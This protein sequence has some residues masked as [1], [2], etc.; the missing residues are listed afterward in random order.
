MANRK[1]NK[2][3]H[4]QLFNRYIW[5]IDLIYSRKRITFE[6]ICERW[7]R[8]TLNNSGDELPLRTFHNHRK[9]IEQMFDINIECDKRAGYLYYIENS[10]D[11]ER[12]GVRQWLVNTFAVNNLINESH[13][14]KSRILFEEIPSGQ[15][16]LTQIIEAMR[17]GITLE[18][19]YHSFWR[20]H[21]STFIIEPYCVKVF[22]QRWYVVA[23]SVYDDTLRIYSLDR[24][25]ELR[26]SEETYEFPEY[27]NAKEYFSESFG[28]I[29]NDDYVADRVCIKV[30]DKQAAYLRS[31]PLHHSQ[32]ETQ[33][34]AKYSV[35]E[36]Y[37]KPTYD[38]RQELL[39]HGAAVEVLSPQWFR[40]E[41]AEEIKQQYQNYNF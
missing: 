38:L 1:S 4:A 40:D 3:S 39:S 21:S 24:I 7:Q 18:M 5:L 31:L 30:Y 2:E 22:K 15:S 16:Y 9:A 36:L 34:E 17:D 8:S 35:F 12:G 29:T 27:F 26:L 20:N 41:V 23:H 13:K 11:M 25:Q 33:T 28:V 19:T 32:V 14:L 10:D 6:E 37:V